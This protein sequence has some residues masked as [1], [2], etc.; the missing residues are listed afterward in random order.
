M[1]EIPGCPKLHLGY[2]DVRDC[3]KA[4]LLA[5]QTPDING[6]RIILSAN[7]AWMK[8]IVLILAEEFNHQGYRVSTADIGY[9][10]L[11][12]ASWFDS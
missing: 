1:R 11:K 3:A 6:G 10:P 12:M 7:S 9:C 4:H 2:V 8:D 5:V